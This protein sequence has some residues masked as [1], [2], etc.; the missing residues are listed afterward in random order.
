MSYLV[1]L[2]LPNIFEKLMQKQI[3]GSINIFLSP[4]SCRYRKRFTTK[5][6]LL[7]LTEKWSKG[8]DNKGFGRAVLMDPSI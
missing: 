6:G 8:L 3:N 7:F 5:L 2:V 1:F 4:Y